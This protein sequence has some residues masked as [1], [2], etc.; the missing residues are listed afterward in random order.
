MK[1]LLISFSLVLITMTSSA[2]NKPQSSSVAFKSGDK[3][4]LTVSGSGLGVVSYP[5]ILEQDNLNSLGTYKIKGHL[6]EVDMGQVERFQQQESVILRNG[7]MA[8]VGSRVLN[9]YG[10]VE[11]IAGIAN[12]KVQ[13]QGSGYFIDASQYELFD[14]QNSL[15]FNGRQVSTG[16]Y[17]QF[18]HNYE[19]HLKTIS[20]I[21]NGHVL[22]V[23]TPEFGNA[24]TYYRQFYISS[25]S[26]RL[27]S[28]QLDDGTNV[29]VGDQL[30]VD[31]WKI[32]PVSKAEKNVRS[33]VQIEKIAE[34]CLKAVG[35][36]QF[37]PIRYF[38][39]L[40]PIQEK[41]ID[42]L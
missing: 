24:Q 21:A 36:D 23:P 35:S 34:G 13:T 7:M 11:V 41:P 33:K 9:I 30:I 40:L 5:A 2:Q 39:T 20:S 14:L 18:R 12:G 15:I 8:Q 25:V 37:K 6:T 28:T 31:D 22:I 26:Q 16:D 17:V 19:C 42:S 1:T 4:L 32:D 3:V 38:S 10:K 29:K 27:D